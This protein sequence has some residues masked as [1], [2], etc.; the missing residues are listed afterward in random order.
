MRRLKLHGRE[1]T[2]AAIGVLEACE[3]EGLGSRIITVSDGLRRRCVAAAGWVLLRA[4]EAGG[5]VGVGGVF[6]D[7]CRAN[8][9]DL[10]QPIRRRSS[11]LLD[12]SD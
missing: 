7:L 2:S 8:I 10:I 4:V 11:Y 3:R 12:V 1:C 6:A 5:L 9:S